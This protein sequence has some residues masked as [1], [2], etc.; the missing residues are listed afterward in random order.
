M[1]NLI[2]VPQALVLPLTTGRDLYVDFVYKTLV[3]DA[4]GEPVLDSKRKPQYVRTN[5][6]VGASVTLEIDT[7]PPTTAS[8]VITDEHAVINIDFAV[9]D[10][11]PRNVKWRLKLVTDH[12]DV[13]VQGRTA[14]MEP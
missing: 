7:E 4:D 8:A 6:P 5:Y 9:T 3:V 2:G 12:D 10:D 13:P 11:I 14:R 1:A